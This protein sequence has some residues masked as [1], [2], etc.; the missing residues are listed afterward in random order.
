MAARQQD[1]SNVSMTTR[2]RRRHRFGSSDNDSLSVHDF[3]NSW[4]IKDLQTL[5][6]DVKRE[7][8]NVQACMRSY[9]HAMKEILVTNFPK[10]NSNDFS[11]VLHDLNQRSTQIDEMMKKV[12]EKRATIQIGIKELTAKKESVENENKILAIK[13]ELLCE[14]CSRC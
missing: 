14:D 9:R 10:A 11:N 3:N 13:E 12:Q 5:F 7:T 6:A 2:S 1:D 4:T 8:E